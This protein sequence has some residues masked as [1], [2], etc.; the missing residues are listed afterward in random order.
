MGRSISVVSVLVCLVLAPLGARA[1]SPARDR[2]A[3]G[4]DVRVGAGEVVEDAISFGGDTIIEGEVLG[5]AVSFGGSVVL[6]DGGHVR[7]D[8]TSFGGE[9]RDRSRAFAG[10]AHYERGPIERIGEWIGDAARSAVAHVL[11]FLL[12]LVLIGAARDRL[13]AMQ[14]TMIEDGLKTAGVGALGY[15]VAVIG[16]VLFA[17]TILGIPLAIVLALALP[18]GTYVGLAA[19]ATVIGALLPIRDRKGREILQLA[20]GV[21]VLFVATLVP[22]AGTFITIGAS[23]LGFGALLRTRF[24][25]TPPNDLPDAGAYR[26]PASV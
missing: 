1:Q 22:L 15:V 14:V 17:I 24:A 8:V 23:C 9:V 25:L 5:D 13:R 6:R 3:F 12:G 10:H 18:I 21:L 20:A 19:A 11:I 7:G 26:T 2:V 16:I 4:S